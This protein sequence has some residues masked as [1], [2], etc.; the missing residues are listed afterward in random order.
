MHTFARFFLGTAAVALLIS[1]SARAQ[2]SLTG[3]WTGAVGP[4]EFTLHLTD[5]AGGPRTATLD[6]PAQHA[7]GL[8]LQFTAPRD[9][10]YL[11]L[12]QPTA[13]FAGRWLG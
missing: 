7:K 3:D 2:T 11:R 9:S 1:S 6:I 4:I 10:V 13:Q 12:A 5:P 8:P